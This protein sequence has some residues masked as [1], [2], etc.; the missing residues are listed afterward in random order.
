MTH[1]ARTELGA[2]LG[3]CLDEL[4]E[5]DREVILLRVAEGLSNEEAAQEL[6]EA[7]N[8]VSHRYRRALGKLRE[9]V[10]RS[11]LDELSEN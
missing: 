7:P 3:R 2:A 9:A 10:P 11:F 1:A 8:T 5:K 4:Q 6:G